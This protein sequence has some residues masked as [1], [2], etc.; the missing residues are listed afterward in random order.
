MANKND[1]IMMVGIMSFAIIFFISLLFSP[2]YLENAVNEERKVEYKIEFEAVETVDEKEYTSVSEYTEIEQNLIYR[3]FEDG[4]EVYEK[5][6]VTQKYETKLNKTQVVSVNGVI[7][8]VRSTSEFETRGEP[9]N[10]A[11]KNSGIIGFVGSI[12][13]VILYLRKLED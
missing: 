8:I 1:R 5:K 12:L 10:Q 9:T 2:L 4:E 13:S 11:Y 6:S 3:S 7:G